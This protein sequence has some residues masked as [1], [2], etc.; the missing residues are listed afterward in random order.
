MTVSSASSQIEVIPVGNNHQPLLVESGKIINGADF[1]LK[2][3][4]RKIEIKK[5]GQN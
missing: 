4:Q 5:F 3:K 2:V 1:T